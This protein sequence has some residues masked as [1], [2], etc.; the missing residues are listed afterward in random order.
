MSETT[1]G[2]IIIS[3]NLV[4]RA[5]PEFNDFEVPTVITL[6][7]PLRCLKSSTNFSSCYGVI[8]VLSLKTSLI[9]SKKY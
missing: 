9:H 8:A 6:K 1:Y 5:P 4:L 3:E 7:S 2:E